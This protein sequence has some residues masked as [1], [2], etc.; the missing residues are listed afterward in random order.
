MTL[1]RRRAGAAHHPEGRPQ[2]AAG[3]GADHRADGDAARARSTGPSPSRPQPSDD[4]LVRSGLAGARARRAA[5]RGAS[6]AWS[7]TCRSA[8]CCRAAS[9]PA[10][11]VGLLAEAGQHGPE[12]FS[13]GFED[14]R[15]R[16]G[17]RVPVFRPDRQALRHRPPQASSSTVARTLP[18][19]C[20]TAIAG[21]VRADG[22]P[23]RR[24]ASTCCR[25]RSPSTSRSCRAARA[26]TRS[27]PATT[28]IRR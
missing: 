15:R 25:R 2:A 4:G 24:S 26:P 17:R 7:P 5:H 20:R 27:S 6:G 3:D 28:G 10:S 19:A 22:Q 13:I 18:A 8:C 12:T 11:I 14:G 9:T 23:R 1:P 21:D 16:E